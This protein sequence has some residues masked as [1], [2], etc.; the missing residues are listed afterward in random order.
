MLTCF[1]WK[2]LWFSLRLSLVVIHLADLSS[3]SIQKAESLQFCGFLS[4]VFCIL[5]TY[6]LHGKNNYHP[7]WAPRAGINLPSRDFRA[8]PLFSKIFHTCAWFGVQDPRS[9]RAL[10]RPVRYL[11]NG[12]ELLKFVVR[13]CPNKHFH[14]PVKRL[15]NANWS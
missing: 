7:Q 13:K 15:T 11:T 14:G 5:V 10:K 2:I 4:C 6:G 3:V 9:R 8:L 12:Q 1:S